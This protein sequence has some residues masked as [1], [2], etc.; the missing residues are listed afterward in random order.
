MLLDVLHVLVFFGT[1]GAFGGYFLASV[2]F[3]WLSFCGL[4]EF[5]KPFGLAIVW[6]A[7]KFFEFQGF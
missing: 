6:F 2:G 1:F 4:L 3:F 7:L 5:L